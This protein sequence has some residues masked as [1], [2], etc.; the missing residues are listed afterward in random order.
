MNTLFA[1]SMVLLILIALV[2]ALGIIARRREEVCNAEDPAENG[3]PATPT[4]Q[5]I[6]AAEIASTRPTA[7]PKG[8]PEEEITA[9]MAA[10][11]RRD[12]AIQV[13]ENQRA[14]D[15]AVAASKKKK[16]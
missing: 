8:I 13:I 16:A 4:L 15:K 14:E 6:A 11:L 5:E 10:G 2:I 12:Q 3:E 7:A 9:K 1:L